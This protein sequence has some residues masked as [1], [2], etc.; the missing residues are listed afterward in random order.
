MPH[1]L[2]HPS[3]WARPTSTTEL[4]KQARFLIA[5]LLIAGAL[6]ALRFFYPHSGTSIDRSTPIRNEPVK[7]R[8][9]PASQ[10]QAEGKAFRR[11]RLFG[12]GIAFGHS[13]STRVRCRIVSRIRGRCLIATPK[14]YRAVEHAIDLGAVLGPLLDLVVNNTDSRWE[15]FISPYPTR[16]LRH[17]SASDTPRFNST[18]TPRRS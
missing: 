17:Q 14:I 5:V 4:T 15:G 1:D 2:T 6:F 12:Y 16:S 9:R 18:S 8:C 3:E 7:N 10:R 13:S 11:R